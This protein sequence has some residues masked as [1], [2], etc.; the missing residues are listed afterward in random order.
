MKRVLSIQIFLA[1]ATLLACAPA[2]ADHGSSVAAGF[3]G[4]GFGM[5][6]GMALADHHHS[7][8]YHHNHYYHEPIRTRYVYSDCA[9]PTC[10]HHHHHPCEEVHIYEHRR[11]SCHYIYENSPCT[12]VYISK[13]HCRPCHHSSFS[14]GFSL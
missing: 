10:H 7:H 13:H 9:Y 8:C 14:F 4:A 11:P 5:M 12:D 6:A 1:A 2:K 3:L